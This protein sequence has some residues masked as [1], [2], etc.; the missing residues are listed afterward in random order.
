MYLV[1]RK[2]AITVYTHPIGRTGPTVDCVLPQA[3]WAWR[4][5]FCLSWQKQGESV[6]VIGNFSPAFVFA[7]VQV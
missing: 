2:G 3:R 5:W 7:S 4:V 1:K 6:L